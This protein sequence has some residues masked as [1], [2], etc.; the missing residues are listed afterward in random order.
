MCSD[1]AQV[2]HGLE[3]RS[4][5]CNDMIVTD[6]YIWS[7]SRMWET[8]ADWTSFT[9][10]CVCETVQQCRLI[11]Q[12]KH[13]TQVSQSSGPNTILCT[14]QCICNINSDYTL[15]IGV[16]K[17]GNLPGDVVGKMPDWIRYFRVI[18]QS[19]TTGLLLRAVNTSSLSN[20]EKKTIT[21]TRNEKA[22]VEGFLL[23]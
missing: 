19:V 15:F 12:W 13:L 4:C 17:R 9:K 11:T 23:K 2:S 8:W 21:V 10:Q 1:P 16:T 7:H 18:F 22:A 6:F 14:R 3:Y 20:N 5:M